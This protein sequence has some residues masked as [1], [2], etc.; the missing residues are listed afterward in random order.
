MINEINSLTVQA[1]KP[2]N[3]EGETCPI[4]LEAFGMYVN[5]LSTRACKHTFHIHC[6]E[7][8]LKFERQ[9][10]DRAI[11]PVCRVD[12]SRLA[13][14]LGVTSTPDQNNDAG[15]PLM[16]QGELPDGRLV[17]SWSDDSVIVSWSDFDGQPRYTLLHPRFYQI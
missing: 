10:H 2:E 14:A 12:L 7:T 8:S 3:P 1:A 4:C 5:T 6:I 17:S 13:N 16:A 15:S 9:L 11:C